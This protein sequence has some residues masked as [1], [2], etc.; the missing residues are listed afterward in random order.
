LTRGVDIHRRFMPTKAY[1]QGAAAFDMV[2]A[3]RHGGL[4]PCAYY[5]LS[6]IGSFQTSANAHWLLCK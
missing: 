6:G 5:S 1:Y 4:L 2:R 3:N